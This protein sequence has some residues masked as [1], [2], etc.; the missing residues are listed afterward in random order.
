[1][2]VGMEKCHVKNLFLSSQ[3][4]LQSN[5]DYD[6]FSVP[7]D[8]F[9]TIPIYTIHLSVYAIISMQFY[10]MKEQN[11][12][13]SSV[14]GERWGSAFLNWRRGEIYCYYILLNTVTIKLR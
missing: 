11:G 2:T 6:N 14:E 12:M 3:R 10:D 5:H 9:F 1:M 13:V 4:R 7:T 8:T